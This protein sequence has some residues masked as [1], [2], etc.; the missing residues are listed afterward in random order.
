MKMTAESIHR[1]LMERMN[2]TREPFTEGNLKQ[3]AS[4]QD[5]DAHH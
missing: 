2:E 3:D 5:G 1:W 4:I